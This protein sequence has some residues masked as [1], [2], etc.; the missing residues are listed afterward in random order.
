MA[1]TSPIRIGCSGWNYRHWRGPFY[2]ESL[3]VKD[4]FG[5]YAGRFDTVEINNSFY[6]LPTAKTFDAWRIQAPPDFLY[7]VKAN[8]YLTQAKKLKEC[9]EPLAR[10]IP[11]MRHLEEALG[12]ILYQLPPSLRLNL[13]RLEAFLAMLPRDLTHVFE[14]RDASWYRDETL[15]MLDRFGAGFVVHDF[16]GRVS[17]QWAASGVAYV[18]LHGAAGKYYGRYA[19]E[20]LAD[21]RDW[22]LNQ[23]RAGRAVWAYFNNDTDAA[24]ID[25]A[26]A[27]RAMVR[28][29]LGAD[30]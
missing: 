23:A 3:G 5:F 6:R 13:D 19:R 24:A 1:L 18:R 17:P 4:W 15:S 30:P 9:E 8:R 7:A 12:P 25:D 2:P 26:L 16:P 28:R 21:W 14:F 29:A 10:M 20:V 22:M 27:L 11:P